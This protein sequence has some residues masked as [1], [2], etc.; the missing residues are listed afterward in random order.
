MQFT[1]LASGS[2]GNCTYLEI[3]QNI[4]LI[5][6]GISLRQVQSRLEIVHKTLTHLEGVFITHEHTDHVSGLVSVVK[7]FKPRVYMT[8]GTY[9]N[10][11]K[12]ILTGLDPNLIE[13]INFDQI[14]MPDGFTVRPFMTYH[15]A[16]EP[17]GYK[18]T[19]AGKSL[20]YMTDSGYYPQ[21]HFDIIRNA[22]AYIVE[23]NHE[24]EMLLESDRP[25]LLK[26]RILDDQGHLSNEDSAF[27]LINVIGIN[28]KTIILAH[29]SEECNTPE[30]A[31]SVYRRVF[32]EQGLIYDDYKILYA[33]QDYP[34]QEVIL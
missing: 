17:C 20:V 31:L 8:E 5:D 22:D 7:K 26:K 32:E 21:K 34:L 12:M 28:T 33:M 15:D 19:E 1:I 4:Y 30:M 10:L 3:G 6:L 13:L 2:K 16:L 27:L 24:P 14:L 11:P 18:F 9:K 25:W 29:L 23:S